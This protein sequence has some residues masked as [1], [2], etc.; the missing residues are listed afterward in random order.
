MSEPAVRSPRCF[1]RVGELATIRPCALCYAVFDARG[2]A[3]PEHNLV[4]R[5]AQVM[6]DDRLPHPSRRTVP[7]RHRRTERV[8]PHAGIEVNLEETFQ[9]ES[10][11]WIL[12]DR[13]GVR[14]LIRMFTRR[15]RREM[16]RSLAG[17]E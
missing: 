10:I 5:P 3:I 15:W 12:P 1:L 2:F 8:P 7:V 13:R 14:W 16:D 11:D 4:G 17:H 6:R 9:T